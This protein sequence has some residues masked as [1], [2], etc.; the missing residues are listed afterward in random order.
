[1]PVELRLTRST[2]STKRQRRRRPLSVKPRRPSSTS[3]LDNSLVSR[4]MPADKP[5]KSSVRLMSPRNITRL[6][7]APLRDTMPAELDSSQL[8]KSRQP[9][10]RLKL[11]NLL[12]R[13]ESLT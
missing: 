10:R 6:D 13:E 8:T 7:F 1:M 9:R 4:L 2:P 12:I 5:S 3:E 11:R